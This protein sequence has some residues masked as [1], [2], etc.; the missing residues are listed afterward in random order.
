VKFLLTDT[1]Q[2]HDSPQQHAQVWRARVH[3][4]GAARV[5]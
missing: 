1:T 2:L 5:A 3:R 4:G